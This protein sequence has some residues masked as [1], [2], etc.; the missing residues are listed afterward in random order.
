MVGPVEFD[1]SGFGCGE[2]WKA[3]EKK[4]GINGASGRPG[5]RE[6]DGGKNGKLVGSAISTGAIP[7]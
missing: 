1:P 4:G 7:K 2:N 6:G 5:W 3:E